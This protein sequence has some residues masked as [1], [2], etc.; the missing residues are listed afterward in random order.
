LGGSGG[1][2]GRPVLGRAAAGMIIKRPNTG[3]ASRAHHDAAVPTWIMTPAMASCRARRA[4]GRMGEKSR[5]KKDE[6]GCPAA[7]LLCAPSFR[8]AILVV[9]VGNRPAGLGAGAGGAA[10][11]TQL[12]RRGPM[13]IPS[14]KCQKV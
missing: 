10:R 13:T 3:T 6:W 1:G 7:T 2:G 11:V 14:S 12:E 9:K 5:G 8:W 4:E